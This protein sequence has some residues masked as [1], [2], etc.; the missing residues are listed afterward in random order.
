M[1]DKVNT[2]SVSV[3]N[4]VKIEYKMNISADITGRL[5]DTLILPMQYWPVTKYSANVNILK[6]MSALNTHDNM[7][8][9]Y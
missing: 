1:Q 2:S 8:I 3:D 9:C 6:S 7:L 5:D 4:S